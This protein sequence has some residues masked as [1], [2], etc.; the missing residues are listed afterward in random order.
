M[1]GYNGRIVAAGRFDGRVEI[2]PDLSVEIAA[3]APPTN[4]HHD[5]VLRS[6]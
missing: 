3:A 6:P 1:T 4:H 5:V 2:G